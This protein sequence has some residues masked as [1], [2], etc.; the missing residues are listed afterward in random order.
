MRWG[1]NTE[2]ERERG[3]VDPVDDTVERDLIS[4]LSLQVLTDVAP[5]EVPLFG[6]TSAAYFA[7]PGGS[8][9][10]GRR[11]EMLGFGLDMAVLT[12]AVLGAVTPVVRFLV[13]E[14]AETAKD[15]ASASL[16][17]FVRRLFRRRR[18]DAGNDGERGEQAA[19]ILTA[20]QVRRARELARDR[21]VQLGVP[22]ETACLLADSIAGGLLA[23]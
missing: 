21:A 20:D 18:S 3:G 1:K 11:D 22:Q 10:K 5:Q 7:R 2:P 16:G 8:R 13:A 17:Q 15:E 12:P 19:T 9:R 6:A 14:L 23:A 4:E